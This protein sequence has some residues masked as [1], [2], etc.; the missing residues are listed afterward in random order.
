MEVM[1]EVVELAMPVVQIAIDA[2]AMHEM[3]RVVGVGGW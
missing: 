3:T 1:I 2:S